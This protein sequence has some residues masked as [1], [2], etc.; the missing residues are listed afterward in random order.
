MSISILLRVP[1]HL[2][3]PSPQW[4]A[5]SASPEIALP[6]PLGVNHLTKSGFS[7]G[8]CWQNC[9]FL[10]GE[11]VLWRISRGFMVFCSNL[12]GFGGFL[13]WKIG[14]ALWANGSAHGIDVVK[15]IATSNNLGLSLL[16]G[17]QIDCQSSTSI[18]SST[19]CEPSKRPPF[20]LGNRRFPKRRVPGQ[21]KSFPLFQLLPSMQDA[22]AGCNV[23]LTASGN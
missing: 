11:R 4:L 17:L 8:I 20:Q 15:K 7:W 3:R 14:P 12:L 6:V 19:W 16:L 18:F 21:V 10:W 1:P 23:E 2:R 22:G 9:F 13:G 5:F